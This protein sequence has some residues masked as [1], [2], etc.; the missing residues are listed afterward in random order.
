M[1]QIT[2]SNIKIDVVR[3]EIK[4]I[5]LAVYPPT[6]RVRIAA[7]IKTNESALRLFAISKLGWIKRIQGKFEVQERVSEREYKQRE[8]HYFQGRRYLLNIVESD[9][10]PKVVLKNKKFIELHIRPGTTQVKRN[11]IMTEWYR[12]ELKKQIPAII[13]KWE[14]ILKINVDDWK[15]QKMKT[16]W[17]TCNIEKRRILLNLE[18]AKKPEHCLEYIIVHEMVHLL[19]RYHNDRFLYY[20]DTY[21]SSWRQLRTELNRLPVSHAD[22]CY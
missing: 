18:L 19:E 4:N 7:P 2:I 14:K 10:I 13:S 3:K 11:K 15:V 21:L 6:G 5:H 1:E 16:K 20:M 22:W 17:G 12:F 9:T 8:S